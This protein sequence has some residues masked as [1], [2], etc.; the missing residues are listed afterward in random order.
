MDHTLASIARYVDALTFEDLDEKTVH[1]A[2]RR[3]VDGF[4]CALGAFDAPL[5]RSAREI[6]PQGLSSNASRIWGTDTFTT[7]EAAAFANGVMLREL[8]LSDMYRVKSGGHPSDVISAVLAMS[9]VENVTVGDAILAIVAAYEV[10]C[11]FCETVDINSQGWD[12]PVYGVMAS[13][14]GAAK[15]LNLDPERIAQAIALAITPNMA[16]AQT[17][18]GNI[19]NWKGAA[20]ANAARNGLYAAVL[21]KAGFEGPEE[22]FEG[23]AGLWRV[24][25]KQTWTIGQGSPRINGTHIKQYAVC[26]HG[27]GAIQAALSIRG[28][29]DGAEIR[30]VKIE[31]YRQAHTYMAGEPNRW[32]P[33]TRETADHS[34]PFVTATALHYGDVT[35]DSFVQDRL[36]DP[37]LKRL[38][39]VTDVT[40]D[41]DLASKY[42]T[43]A[44]CRLTVE[45]MG[46][47]TL[48][49]HV[50]SPEGH[51]DNPLS[52]DKLA[53]K[54]RDRA[55]ANLSLAGCDR[56]LETLWNLEPDQPA[57]ILSA[58]LVD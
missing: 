32:A 29:I 24:L 20:A 5:S 37:A 18:R 14:A 39:D 27:Q 57:S 34:L 16:L 15:V 55:S 4:A 13:A 28:D 43:S 56:A 7:P 11:T 48:V 52:D 33:Q 45:L 49:T 40:V 53:Q 25:G 51:S 8:D 26:Y 35:E 46:D 41:E 9:E 12:Q 54:F 23:A 19:C 21:A 50:A 2:K 36:S 30:R 42:P 44:P 17:R 3:L 31:T 47:R 1:E 22:A 38:M 58:A 10:Y 6:A